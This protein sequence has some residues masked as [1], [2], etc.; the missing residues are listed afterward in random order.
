MALFRLALVALAAGFTAA[1]SA[2]VFRA[3]IDLVHFT[4]TAV[5]RK[6]ELV[7]NLTRNDFEIREDGDPQAIEYFAR[8]DDIE[9]RPELHL[10][11]LFDTSGS[12]GEDVKMSRTAAV[13][14]LNALPDAED[15]TLVDFDTEV[16][17]TRY[18]QA[19]FPRMVERIRKRQPDGWTAFY[20]AIGVYL[21]G[22]NGQTGRKVLVL[23]TDGGDTRSTM[24][25]SEMMNLVKASDVI[26]YA[27]GFLEHQLSSQRHDQRMRLHQISDTT[28]GQAF[29]PSRAE[30]LDDMYQKIVDELRG[31]YS[32]GYSSTNKK[33][34]GTWRKVEVRLTRP[35]LKGLK[36]RTRKGYFAPY[37]ED[38]AQR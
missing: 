1:P 5:D 24:N 19:D 30:E 18:G 9:E 23:Y 38:A 21:D 25:Y 29:F 27:I 35:D 12:M 10:G 15:M 11:L 34:D 16:R 26:V 28:G 36:L 2:Q 3:G 22:A 13:K 4:V 37:R 8:G 31:H 7:T 17:V 14:F 20:D 33:Q 6:G 32:L